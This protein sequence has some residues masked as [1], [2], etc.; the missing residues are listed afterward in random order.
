MVVLYTNIVCGVDAS[1]YDV[2]RVHMKVHSLYKRIG[3]TIKVQRRALGLTQ[4]ELAMRLGISRASLANIETGRQRIL[5]HQL[6]ELAQQLKIGIQRL[7]P[8]SSEAEA[9]Q[10]LDDLLFS[11]NVSVSQRLQ[12]ATLLKEDAITPPDTGDLND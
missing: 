3:A 12:I 2:Y 1:A 11:E 4:H 5:V 6:Y 8:D 10:A 9:L 7:L